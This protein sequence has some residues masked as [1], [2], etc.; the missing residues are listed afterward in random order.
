MLAILGLFP[1]QLSTAPFD[2]FKRDTAERWAS[3][4]RVGKRAVK[5]HLGPGDD[6]ITL[7]GTLS[8]EIT[9]GRLSLDILRIM[10]SEGKAWPYIDGEGF[11]YGLWTIKSISE[12]RTYMFKDGAPRQIDFTV[13]IE[14]ADSSDIEKIGVLTRIGLSLLR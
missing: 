13:T 8:P 3:N 14:R 11:I 4:A 6:V 10:Q 12:T 2:E 5:Q 1:F 7:S 9:G